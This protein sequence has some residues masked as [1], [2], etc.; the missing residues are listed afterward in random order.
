[1][2]RG[3]ELFV[4]LQ[5]LG[6]G[7]PDLLVRAGQQPQVIV[8]ADGTIT[9]V[10]DYKQ[11]SFGS[12]SLYVASTDANTYYFGVYGFINSTY[13]I[14]ATWFTPGV[15]NTLLDGRPQLGY[16]TYDNPRLYAFQVTDPSQTK[17]ISFVL[18]S[19]TIGATADFYINA[20]CTPDINNDVAPPTPQN[21]MW[22]STQTANS[23]IR[24][25]L[26]ISPNGDVNVCFNGTYLVAGMLSFELYQSHGKVLSPDMYSIQFASSFV[27]AR[28][29]QCT[30]PALL[31]SAPRLPTP[32]TVCSSPC[33]HRPRWSSYQR[34]SRTLARCVRATT[35]TLKW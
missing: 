5:D 24:N 17:E 6:G 34:A 28:C 4:S 26:T 3:R 29:L 27:L 23:Q 8:N 7:D 30:P 35:S 12:D 1:V 15:F 13:V 31:R 10:A 9:V 20:D 11:N 2:P 25:S 14:T 33:W 32:S 21:Y 16:V 22:A 18:Q 19:S